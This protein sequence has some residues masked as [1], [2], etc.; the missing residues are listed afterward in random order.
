MPPSIEHLHSFLDNSI[1]CLPLD[2]HIVELYRVIVGT[3]L[4]S[5]DS[6]VRSPMFQI[7]GPV[8]KEEA[9]LRVAIMI[10]PGKHKWI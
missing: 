7:Y 4:L 6:I 1:Q 5:Q 3:G 8:W 9:S 10:A 2:N